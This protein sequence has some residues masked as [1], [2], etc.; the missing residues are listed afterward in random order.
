MTFGDP[1]VIVPVLVVA[2]TIVTE[3][4]ILATGIPAT[5]DTGDPV[6]TLA[7]CPQLAGPV[8]PTSTTG[9]PSAVHTELP[10]LNVAVKLTD[11][12]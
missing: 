3:S 11:G 4:P 9:C 7:V 1:D 12:E 5:K 6:V 8:W 10:V 2:S